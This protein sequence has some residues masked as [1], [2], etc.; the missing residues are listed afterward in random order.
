[1]EV[2]IFIVVL[3]VLILVHELGHFI[4]AKLSGMRVEEFGIGYPPRALTIGK[5]GDT[6]YTL[7]WL[8]FGGFV[9]IYGE[10]GENGEEPPAE[11]EKSRAFNSKPF[12]LKA[13]VL[14]AG[15]A[16]NLVFAWA[17]FLTTLALGT[18]Q[19][20]TQAQSYTVKDATIALAAVRPGSP[21]DKAGFL[22]GDE[23]KNSVLPMKGLAESYNG[24][25]PAAFSTLVAMDASGTPMQFTV[26][27]N[28]K[29]IH[30]TAAPEMKTIPGAPTRPGFGFTI[31]AVGTV[32]TPLK[33][34]PYQG[35]I[36]TWNVT[37]ETAVALGQFFKGIVTFSANL[38]EISGPVGIAN[39]VGQASSNGI[40][41]LLSLVALISVNLALVNLI[42]VPAL[43]GGRLLFVIIEAIIRRP[44]N[45]KIADTVN[46]V[47]FALLI[48][49]MIVV[50]GHDIY[51]LVK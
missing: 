26:N 11:G 19:V 31:S 1:M 20:L 4:V 9:R 49:L 43:D 45:P 22:P 50:T 46:M 35:L 6:L 5:L 48:L 47:G 2:L 36:L 16:M 12:I 51:S 13:L 41:A 10:E 21:A 33:D 39:A 14:L 18:E 25:D 17:L 29:T 7:N 23:I 8:P 15:I 24:A 37:K 38:A 32:K 3:V 40:S 42:P 44:L 30:I 27:R 34:V 28:G